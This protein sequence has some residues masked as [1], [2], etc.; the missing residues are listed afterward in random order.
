MI[1]Y[2]SGTGNSK[3]VAEEIAKGLGDIAYD[4]T[5]LKVVENIKKEKNIGLVFPVYA[6]GVPEAMIKFAKK[7]P[8]T[9]AFTF[10]VCTCGEDAG[11]SMKKLSKIYHLDSSYS[12]AMPNN[13]LIG[14][15]LEDEETVR[16]KIKFS[17]VKVERIIADIGLGRKVYDVHEG[18]KAG[19]KSSFVNK[20]FNQFARSTKSFSVNEN[21]IG[22]GL[23]EQNCPAKTI[24]LVDNKP[25]WGKKCYQCLKCINLCPK[26]AIQYGKNT[27]NR[28]RYSIEKYL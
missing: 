7:I 4:I 21:C 6:W 20:G 23:C 16:E 24:K 13:Y 14:S 5:K 19:L 25:T 27:E 3:W 22:C 1:F 12:L 15:E 26:E 10:G 2:F 8:K 11:L 28:K 17:K 18:S 9:E